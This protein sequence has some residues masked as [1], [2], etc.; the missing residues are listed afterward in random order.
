MCVDGALD[1]R[2]GRETKGKPVSA[3]V[4]IIERAAKQALRALEVAR[5]IADQRIADRYIGRGGAEASRHFARR[6]EGAPVDV[7]PHQPLARPPDFGLDRD[8]FLT[9]LD[10]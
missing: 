2:V 1:D 10:C 5:A 7:E 3:T 9:V 8:R 4:R 6:G